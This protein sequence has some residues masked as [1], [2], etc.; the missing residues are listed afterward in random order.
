MQEDFIR[1]G[2]RELRPLTRADVAQQVGIHEF[3][4]QPRHRRKIR[5]ATE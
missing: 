5:D 2:V 4:R 3:D 1:G